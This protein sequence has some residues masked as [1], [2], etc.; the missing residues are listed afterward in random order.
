MNMHWKVLMGWTHCKFSDAHIFEQTSAH[1]CLVFTHETLGGDG[2]ERGYSYIIIILKMVASS[3][4]VRCCTNTFRMGTC[5]SVPKHVV[6]NLICTQVHLSFHSK[7]VLPFSGHILKTT[8]GPKYNK[9]L[10]IVIKSRL[11][12]MTLLGGN[13][14]QST[15]ADALFL[16]YLA[17]SHSYR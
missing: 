16:S 8:I 7:M 2:E 17:V 6:H 5:Y 15:I 12:I 4:S 11:K 13:Q 10:L 14:N 3:Y 9:R 1:W